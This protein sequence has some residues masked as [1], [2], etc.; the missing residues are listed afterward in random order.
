MLIR[1][2]LIVAI[3]AGFATA[4]LN[5]FKVREKIT[6]LQTTL[7]S[8]QNELA[9]TK[10]DLANTRTDLEKTK[11]DLKKTQTEL[12]DT[13]TERDNAVAEAATQKKQVTSLRDQLAKMKQ[14]RDDAQADLSAW[15]ALGPSVDQI[16]DIIAQLKE[17]QKARD[18]L[19]EKLAK[20]RSAYTKALSELERYSSP[21][22]R[23]VPLPPDLKGKVVVVDPKFDF[24]VADVGEKQGAV[25]R[26][27]LLV[28]RNGKLVAKV[29]IW[30]VLPDRCVANVLPG[31]KLTDVVEGDL[32]VPAL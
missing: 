5:L 9:N 17:T 4:G 24:V 16:K 20:L 1:I 3:V 31:W 23:P 21:E 25:E 10:T 8:T 22:E 26:G 13:K 28:S 32:V 30:N 29:R 7:K 19:T 12:T 11:E 2:A 18:D 14:E 15:K 6:I 27:L